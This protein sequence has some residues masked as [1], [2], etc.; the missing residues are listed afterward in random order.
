MQLIID[1]FNIKL[2]KLKIN[3]MRA[4]FMLTFF[5][6]SFSF[7]QSSNWWVFFT[8]KDC[9]QVI[10]LS[11]RAIDRRVKQNIEFD[12]HDFS[13]CSDYVDSLQDMNISVRYQLKWFN[14][15]SVSVDSDADL[16]KIKKF[17]FV[18]EVRPVLKM[19][20]QANIDVFNLDFNPT[21]MHRKLFSL[22]YGLSL[23][24]IETLFAAK[25]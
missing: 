9:P 16:Q 11:D 13:I 10:A 7:S 15:V 5:C 20:K 1:D 24:Q 22:P 4:L 19:K 21:Y 8:D 23:N 17:Y 3:Y 18:K 25:A 12:I 2:I 14:A 6:V